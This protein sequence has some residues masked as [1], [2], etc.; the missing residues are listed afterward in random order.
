MSRDNKIK[1]MAKII[2]QSKN[3]DKPC[4]DE[5]YGGWACLTCDY[6]E[7]GYC[8]QDV[9]VATGLH[10]AGYYKVPVGNW[11]DT[12]KGQYANQLYRCSVCGKPAYGDGKIWFLTKFC[13]SCG[14]NMKG[15]VQ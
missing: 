8:Q 9:E 15:E 5:E 10:N 14:A 11:V 6:L 3:K 7:K 1:E 4:L 13:P 12:Y 2:H